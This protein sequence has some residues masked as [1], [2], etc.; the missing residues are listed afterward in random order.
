MICT[1]LIDA[2]SSGGVLGK[3]ILMGG[4]AVHGTSGAGSIGS[5]SE[6]LGGTGEGPEVGVD[7][8]SN[9]TFDQL[10][11]IAKSQKHFSVL[12]VWK[13]FT[14]EQLNG[15][16]VYGG[17]NGNLGLDNLLLERVKSVFFGFY[18]VDLVN[19]QWE[20]QNCV[21]AINSYLRRPRPWRIVLA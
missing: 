2:M 1:E 7:P 11:G 5:D 19:R 6:T 9:Y 13:L 21:R 8:I 14:R 10:H 15:R 16:S 4:M 3:D 12:L 20:W 17:R 18:P